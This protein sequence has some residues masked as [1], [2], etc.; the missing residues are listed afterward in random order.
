MSAAADTRDTASPDRVLELAT[1]RSPLGIDADT[2]DAL[3]AAAAILRDEDT[4]LAG[5]IRILGLEGAVLVQERT[6]DR[7]I[8]VRRLA[9]LDAAQRLV[10]ERLATYDRM[11]DGCGCTVDYDG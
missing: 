7:R 9:S 3:L 8:L 10:D 5:R 11:W 6:P 4:C 1:A 2:L